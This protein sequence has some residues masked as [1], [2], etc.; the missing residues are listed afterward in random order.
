MR[1]PAKGAAASPLDDGALTCVGSARAGEGA[2]N[3]AMFSPFFAAAALRKKE[4]GEER[5]R[6]ATNALGFR[7][8]RC[9][10]VFVRPTRVRDRPMQINGRER[11]G[12]HSAQ[13]GARGGRV[14]R[15]RPR[16]RPGKL[17]RPHEQYRPGQFSLFQL[18]WAK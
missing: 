18:V 1:A 8:G 4:S 9:A 10:G 16:L 11:T 14:C 2:G 3:G 17:Q 5:G 13:A 12:Q 15:P 7:V 6:E